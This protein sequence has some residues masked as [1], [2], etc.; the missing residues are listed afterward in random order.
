MGAVI[1]LARD[2]GRID[3]AFSDLL[4]PN[5]NEVHAANLEDGFLQGLLHRLWQAGLQDRLVLINQKAPTIEG[6][7]PEI[8][9]NAV[10]HTVKVGLKRFKKDVL[11]RETI[12]NVEL[13]LD[14]NEHNSDPA[15]DEEIAEARAHDGRFK[16]I[17]HVTRIDSAASRLLQL[18][19]CVAYARKWIVNGELNAAGLRSRFGIQLP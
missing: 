8:Y 16:G 10:V 1:V 11:N 7:P 3:K 5:A 14:R 18:A 6:S 13:I 19:D 2:A 12:G 15:F 4:E 17:R 9:A